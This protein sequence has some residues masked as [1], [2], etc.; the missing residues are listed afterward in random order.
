MKATAKARRDLD[1]LRSL[2]RKLINE[3]G[4]CRVCKGRGEHGRSICVFCG[5]SGRLLTCEA[6]RTLTT[7]RD[8]LN[9][10]DRRAR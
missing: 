8:T 5:G 9:D 1:T 4:P 7:I 6:T 10:L 2:S 3:L